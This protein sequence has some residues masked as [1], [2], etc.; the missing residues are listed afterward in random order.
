VS[1]ERDRD[2]Q[3]PVSVDFWESAANRDPLWAIL[4]N[5]SKRGRQW[6]LREFFETGRREIS[7]LLYQLDRLGRMPRR[8][9]ALDF[10]CGVGRLTQPLSASFTEVIG[11]DISPT[12]IRI[13]ERLN[14][15]P[16][17]V[18]YVPGNPHDLGQFEADR[19][20]FIYSDIVLQ[21]IP[22]DSSR[23]YIAEFL[24]V[25][26][27]GGVLVFQLPSHRRPAAE[28][29]ALPTPMIDGAYRA[30]LALLEPMPPIVGANERLQVVV[31]ATNASPVAWDQSASGS[32]RI[33]NHW[34]TPAGTMLI[35]D[36]GRANVPALVNPEQA[37]LTTVTV[38]APP[39]PGEYLCD[40]DLVQEGISW[41]H[42]KGSP[43]LRVSVTV[44]GKR[45]L[46]GGHMTATPVY[47]DM[48]PFPDIYDDLQRTAADIGEFPMFGVPREAVLRLIAS[49]GGS[50]FH[51]EPDERGGPEWVGFR[52]YVS[53]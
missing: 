42:D 25:L 41:F 6:D 8:G 50:V 3:T 12:M 2:A 35:Q 26:A 37:F 30:A 24:R 19:F 22:P 20:D 13:A 39:D 5:P 34:L 40:F 1:V 23:R 38:T 21:H 17:R 36:D 14:R 45:D 11:V 52:Y 44:S 53:K 7:L 29:V 43:P 33:G 48:P 9:R 10:G 32:I 51:S 28:Q 46:A 16:D 49:S 47:P 4:S 31:R 15:A 27:P 18:R